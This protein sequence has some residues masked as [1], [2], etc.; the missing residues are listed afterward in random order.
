VGTGAADPLSYHSTQII[1]A[2]TNGS[3]NFVFTAGFGSETI[4]GFAASGT[5]SDTIQLAT[6]AFSY[7]KAGMTQAQDLAA[8]LAKSTENATGLRIADS[9]GDSLTLA[10]L[11]AA[12]IAANPSSITFA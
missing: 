6:S 7:L 4:D 11:T 1:D 8:V 2:T 3:E 5:T 9:H 12:T 10:G